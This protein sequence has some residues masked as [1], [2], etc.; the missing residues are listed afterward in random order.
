MGFGIVSWCGNYSSQYQKQLYGI[1]RYVIS[2]S[3]KVDYL[4]SAC[5]A[6]NVVSKA[7]FV[8]YDAKLSSSY[9]L[10]MVSLRLL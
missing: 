10:A 2:S 4:F 7:L 5:V 9:R 3:F 6:V 1:Y 8:T